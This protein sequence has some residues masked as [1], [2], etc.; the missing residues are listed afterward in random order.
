LEIRLKKRSH[1]FKRFSGFY[2]V[3]FW[4]NPEI[5]LIRFSNAVSG[6]KSFDLSRYRKVIKT[7]GIATSKTHHNPIPL[8]I[9]KGAAPAAFSF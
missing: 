9:R 8:I 7:T 3:N 2:F 5:R 1:L 4:K 6:R